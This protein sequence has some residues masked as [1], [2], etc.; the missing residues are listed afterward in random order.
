[1]PQRPASSD[2]VLVPRS[3]LIELE[4]FL[5]AAYTSGLEEKNSRAYDLYEKIATIRSIT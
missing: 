5:D 2:L 4:Y 3:L 1:M